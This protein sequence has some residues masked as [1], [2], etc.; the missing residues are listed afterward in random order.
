M[1][2]LKTVLLALMVIF[3]MASCSK[4]PAGNVGVKFHLLGQD[5]GV[6]YDVLTPGRYWIGYNEELF[7]YQTY[8]QTKLW[9]SDVRE[10]S[11]TDDDFNFQSNKGLKLSASVSI[12]YHVNPENVP[13]IFETYKRGL[14]E[15]TNKV[16]RN[17]LRDAF[18]MAASK[19]TAE[20]MYGGGK[21]E[22]MEDVINL[23]KIEAEER[24]ITIDDIYLVG[25]I[26]VP[27][28]ITSALEAKIKATQLAQQKENELRQ[29]EADAAKAVVKSQGT[30]DALI[31]KA[32]AEAKANRIVAASLTSNLIDYNRVER[33]DGKLP[34]VTGGAVPFLDIKQ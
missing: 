9:T 3:T 8:N 14:D 20:Q 34:S 33:W 7:L 32:E 23:A 12:E 30:A 1:K 15:V 31:I 6:D 2:S 17:A 19:R 11:Q 27:A 16:L 4:V 28:S 26:I 22:F 10:G 5:K 24:G 21:I 29:T 25:N 13:A 18:N